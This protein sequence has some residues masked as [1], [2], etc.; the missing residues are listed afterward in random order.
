MTEPSGKSGELPTLND[1]VLRYVMRPQRLFTPVT[2]V[3]DAMSVLL[4]LQSR[5]WNFELQ[6]RND[7]I[8]YR[9]SISR[10]VD[11]EVESHWA[12]DPMLPHAICKAALLAC[13][14][15]NEELEDANR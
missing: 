7:Q 4:E 12:F 1:L 13:G 6:S 10:V 11:D 9:V 15:T 14:A 5:G 2:N 8:T 3:A